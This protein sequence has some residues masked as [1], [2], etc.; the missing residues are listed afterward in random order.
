M[1]TVVARKHRL[2]LNRCTGQY[3]RVEVLSCWQKM[4]GEYAASINANKS[5]LEEY[6]I[7]ATKTASCATN[8]AIYLAGEQ[9]VDAMNAI[10]TSCGACGTNEDEI[11]A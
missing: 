1:A 7:S 3:E 2:E 9:T 4:D 6:E 11:E 8:Y 10:C 5:C